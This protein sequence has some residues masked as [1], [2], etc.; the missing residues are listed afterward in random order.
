MTRFSMLAELGWPLHSKTIIIVGVTLVIALAIHAIFAVST[1]K[2][3]KNLRRGWLAGIVYFVFSLLVVALALT[4]FGSMIS[5]GV[6][7]QWALLA[8]IS[9]AG[10]FVFVMLAFAV[11]W[12]PAY[13]SHSGIDRPPTAESKSKPWWL[14]TASLWWLL[15]SSIIAAGSMLVEMLPILDT[16]GMIEVTELHRWAGLAVVVSLAV[17]VY[18]IIVQ[19]AGWR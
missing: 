4:S 12:N 15:F 1:A 14:F 11:V 6:M 16:E 10:A 7:E 5:R 19:R 13:F 9:V 17:N 18:A 2:R 8:H 3:L